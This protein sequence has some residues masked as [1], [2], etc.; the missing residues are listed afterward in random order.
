M[1]GYKGPEIGGM[2]AVIGMYRHRIRIG[3]EIE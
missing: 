1:R 3:M 2:E